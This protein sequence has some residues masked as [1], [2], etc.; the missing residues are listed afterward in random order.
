VAGSATPMRRM[1]PLRG[2][3]RSRHKSVLL[4]IILAFFVVCLTAGDP[5]YTFLAY[6]RIWIKGYF[7]AWVEFPI[8][9]DI[10]V[11]S[12][13]LAERQ[14]IN[15][16]GPPL[17]TELLPYLY[18]P[19]TL[20]GEGSRSSGFVACDGVRNYAI[21]SKAIGLLRP[22]NGS[23][24]RRPAPGR[25]TVTLLNSPGFPTPSLG[26]YGIFGLDLNGFLHDFLDSASMVSRR[27]TFLMCPNILDPPY[28]IGTRSTGQ[29][30]RR[31]ALLET[32]RDSTFS[33][34]KLRMSQVLDTSNMEVISRRSRIPVFSSLRIQAH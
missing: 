19:S 25:A 15:H 10:Y 21:H 8:D 24:P 3:P 30:F 17:A 31:S 26:A 11:G 20:H 34:V 9:D 5:L 7:K 16:Y 23:L 14:S 1:R 33:L 6:W 12:H 18:A 4:L 2:R 29:S 27:L 32:R 28:T 13:H 22:L